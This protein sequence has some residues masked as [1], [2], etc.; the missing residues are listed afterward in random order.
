MTGKALAAVLAVLLGL[1]LVLQTRRAADRIRASA[2][3]Q[4]VETVSM[5]AARMGPAG[6]S[7]LRANLELLHRAAERDP[8]EVGI[9][10][11]IGSMHLLL[12]APQAA[13]DWYEKALALEARPEIYLNLGRAQAALG[14]PAARDSF[15]KALKLD[16][17]LAAQVPEAFRPPSGTP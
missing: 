8:Q 15:E 13:R 17:H 14:D 6:A 1:G 10:L 9:P 5:Q 7:L 2:E 11:A 16:P 4:R 3:L 12:R